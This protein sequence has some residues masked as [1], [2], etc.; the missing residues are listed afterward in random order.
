MDY[1][2]NIKPRNR[3]VSFLLAL[4]FPGL[5]QIYNGQLKKG[6]I[7]F[8]I[9][10]FFPILF[11]LI[12]IAT[13]FYGIV[14]IVIYEACIRIWIIVD[15]II[16]AGKEKE[17]IPRTYNKWYY[18]IFIAILMFAIQYFYNYSSKLGIQ[19]YKQTTSSQFPTINQGD[20]LVVDTRVYSQEKIDYGHIVV[21]KSPH[22]D[23]WIFRVVGLP[24]DTLIIQNNIVSI[25]GKENTAIIIGES[26]FENRQ[27]IELEVELP[28]GHRH[29]ILQ[30]KDDLEQ[31]IRNTEQ[32]VLP[33]N[34]YYLMGDNRDNAYD[35][36]YI[37]PVNI[38][39]IRGRVLYSYFGETT[40]R[41][42]VDFRN[43]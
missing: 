27:V 8:G 9:L 21:F 28:N 43:K 41:I 25:N 15:A 6:F 26:I 24:H 33:S 12:N 35:S 38:N 22:N 19:N 13:F 4:V 40:E 1:E 3:F 16:Q 30:Y 2:T 11:G 36:R 20:M 10:V 37:G 32:I 42:N 7:F 31:V 34:F 39:H 29:R 5:G 14:F 18:Y 17:F 23:Y